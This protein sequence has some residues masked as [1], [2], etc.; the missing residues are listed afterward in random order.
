MFP[1]RSSFR[2]LVLSL[3]LG[4]AAASGSSASAQAGAPSEGWS[5]LSFE[6]AFVQNTELPRTLVSGGDVFINGV[7]IGHALGSQNV[8]IHVEG[9]LEAQQGSVVRGRTVIRGTAAIDS[10]FDVGPNG[11]SQ[12]S[13]LSLADAREAVIAFSQ[14]AAAVDATGTKFITNFGG[15]EFGSLQEGLNV[16]HITAQELAQSNGVV[17][18]RFN[19]DTDTVIINVSGEEARRGTNGAFFFDEFGGERLSAVLEAGNE[20]FHARILWNFHEATTLRTEGQIEGS[21]MAPLAELTH[22]NGRLN[23]QVVARRVNLFN[24]VRLP[25]SS[26]SGSL[27][28]FGPGASAQ[29]LTSY[30]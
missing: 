24:A 6:S 15:I 8:A 14:A 12:D 21:L 25:G 16:F 3:S 7:E 26:F 29:S 27:G 10:T 23:G 28:E 17:I 1:A 18:P 20:S 22:V 2:N 9:R 4:L 5:V 13:P 30:D 11:V 19:P